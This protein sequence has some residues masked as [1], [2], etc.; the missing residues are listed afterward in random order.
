MDRFTSNQ[1]QNYHRP[2]LHISSNTFHQRKCF[3]LCI[4]LGGPLVAAAI[5]PCILVSNGSHLRRCSAVDF[6]GR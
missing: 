2:F 6:C 1:Y 4:Y 3:V 5:W